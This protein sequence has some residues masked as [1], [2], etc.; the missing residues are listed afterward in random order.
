MPK[1]VKFKIWNLRIGCK[2]SAR[3]S[4]TIPLFWGCPRAICRAARYFALFN[5]TKTHKSLKP[6]EQKMEWS[7]KKLKKRKNARFQ[8]SHPNR[9]K[10]SEFVAIWHQTTQNEKNLSK[11]KGAK[12]RAARQMALKQIN[13]KIKIFFVILGANKITGPPKI[14]YTISKY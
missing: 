10:R 11:L 2:T 12:Y 8:R 9:T 6:N 13:I 14:I 4:A 1:T 7:S 5:L 3:N